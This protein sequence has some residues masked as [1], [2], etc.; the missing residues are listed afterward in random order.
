M[1]E[2]RL[3]SSVKA[4]KNQ[5]K[6]SKGPKRNDLPNT[7]C[8]VVDAGAPNAMHMGTVPADITVA[9]VNETFAYLQNSL[10]FPLL[11][12]SEELRS[13]GMLSGEPLNSCED[14]PLRVAIIEEGELQNASRTVDQFELLGVGVGEESS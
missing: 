2:V 6:P 4:N 11:P 13:A 10:C 14:L 5:M 9:A 1:N 12:V 8:Q 7:N 3:I